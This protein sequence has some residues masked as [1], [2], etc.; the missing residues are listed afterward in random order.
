MIYYP[1]VKFLKILANFEHIHLSEV[2]FLL[3]LVLIFD[4][5]EI[6]NVCFVDQAL[7]IPL[8]RHR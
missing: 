2:M 8:D 7:E 3:F 1:S 5:I 6:G 4:N